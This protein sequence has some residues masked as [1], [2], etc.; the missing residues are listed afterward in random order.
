[1]PTGLNFRR[2]PQ[3]LDPYALQAAF[4]EAPVAFWPDAAEILPIGN[5][6][7]LT[8]LKTSLVLTCRPWH[9]GAV[10]IRYP[11]ADPYDP[12]FDPHTEDAPPLA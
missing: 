5:A 9:E 7:P 11:Q 3:A 6:A 8:A 2:A 1:M 12:F 4:I 10:F